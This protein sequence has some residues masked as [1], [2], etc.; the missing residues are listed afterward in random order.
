MVHKNNVSIKGEMVWDKDTIASG[1]N[2]QFFIFLFFLIICF[3]FLLRYMQFKHTIDYSSLLVSPKV[4]SDAYT[5]ELLNTLITN[6]LFFLYT[7]H[8][9]STNKLQISLQLSTEYKG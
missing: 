3:P 7:L 6:N 8:L 2:V 5:K 4:H 1:R 9:V